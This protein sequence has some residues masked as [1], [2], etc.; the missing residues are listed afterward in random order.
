MRRQGARVSRGGLLSVLS[1][2][3]GCVVT[4]RRPVS[5]HGSGVQGVVSNEKPVENENPFLGD[6]LEQ[7]EKCWIQWRENQRASASV[8]L[9]EKIKHNKENQSEHLHT[10]HSPLHKKRPLSWIGTSQ[11]PKP[12]Q[13]KQSD[14]PKS[15]LCGLGD[16]RRKRSLEQEHPRPTSLS[17]TT[18]TEYQ[19]VDPLKSRISQTPANI[20]KNQ[21]LLK[22]GM[23]SRQGGPL[24]HEK[25]EINIPTIRYNFSMQHAYPVN[26]EK[27]P[28]NHMNR[29]RQNK[30]KWRSWNKQLQS[31]L[32]YWQKRFPR[33]TD[34][35]QSSQ[36]IR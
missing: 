8:K 24:F 28:L 3:K 19:D 4:G 31:S 35:I 26:R 11:S 2:S 18:I 32:S 33:T 20:S 1:G 27:Y 25:L 17:K 14:N 7:N 13:R 10:P 16:Y 34:I 29:T 5:W 21:K 6:V 22:T 12:Y 15:L 30:E 36:K 9:R 23:L